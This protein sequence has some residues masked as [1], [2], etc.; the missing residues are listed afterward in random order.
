[1]L[2]PLVIQGGMGV[3]VSSWRLARAVSRTGQLGVVSGTALD[4]VFGRRLQRGDPA[5]DRRRAL[6][7]FPAPAI[8][9]RVLER[10]FIPGGKAAD[11]PFRAIPMASFPPKRDQLELV[12]TANFVEVW[13]AKEG[14]GGA[15]GVNLLEKVQAPTIPALHGAMLAGVDVVLM[16]AGI[17][18]TIP[19]ILDR[20]ARGDAAE[21][22][23]DVADKTPKEEFALAFDPAEFLEAQPPTLARPEF[24]AIVSSATLA[25]MLLKKSTGRVDGFVIEGPT[26][27]GHN[28]P[29]RGPLQLNARGEPIYGQRD[30]ADLA[31]FRALGAPF[32]LA[33]SWGT[34]AGLAR[35]LDEGAAGIQA[36]TL[37]AFCRES[38]LTDE[39]KRQ[40]IELVR[41]GAAD[42]VT[43]PLASPTGFPFKVL[44]LEGS[45]SDAE[46]A[47]QRRLTCDL[48][49][50]RRAYRREDGGVGWRC[51]A[52]D[53][54]A[55]V[56]K[57]GA[58]GETAGR[59]C[60]CNA[61]L[62]NVGLAQLRGDGS[63]E[64]PLVTCGDGIDAIA[65][66]IATGD[67]SYSAEEVV[68]HLLSDVETVAGRS[69]SRGA[70]PRSS[71][72]STPLVIAE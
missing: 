41:R 66:L 7:A 1:M 18:R 42:V 39:L 33:G 57:G 71:A 64:L 37:F 6:A 50:L 12:V 48:G 35:A 40:T 43:D 21:L 28:A 32:W 63:A 38:G 52:E 3:A 56:R 44:Q 5:G 45:L 23:L 26:A 61:L 16:G 19:G 46:L 20:L 10:Y 17:P 67:G 27:G 65:P 58:P 11:V 24:L 59:K 55:F 36:G 29:P 15:V 54:D 22:A 2:A 53:V 9:G 14:H 62:A 49:Y 34:P 4:A 72:E 70:R 31:A 69:A 8:A 47:A 25:S 13:L 68:E 30:N 60:I 51:P